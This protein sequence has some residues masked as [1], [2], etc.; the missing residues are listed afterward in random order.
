[1]I[2][3][4]NPAVAPCS[5]LNKFSLYLPIRRHLLVCQHISVTLRQSLLTGCR[6][7]D[8]IRDDW[9]QYGSQVHTGGGFMVHPLLPTCRPG[10]TM[11]RTYW[12]LCLM[13]GRQM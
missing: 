6:H 11:Q 10:A 3:R 1:M 4:D 13:R 7:M 2:N 5:H 9:L 12:C 8:G